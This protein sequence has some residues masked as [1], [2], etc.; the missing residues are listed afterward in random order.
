MI[1]NREDGTVRR[2]DTRMSVSTGVIRDQGEFNDV[3]YHPRTPNLFV[4]ANEYGSVW[5]YDARMAFE[6]H[7][8]LASEV[9]VRKVSIP[10]IVL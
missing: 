6:G 1:A 7:Q 5:M 3:V 10:L 8:N 9:V 2:Y 4:T